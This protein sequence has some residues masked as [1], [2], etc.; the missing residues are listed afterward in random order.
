MR[1]D[2]R[3][4]KHPPFRGTEVVECNVAKVGFMRALLRLLCVKPI[5]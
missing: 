3:E 5:I 2:Q 1:T 4:P